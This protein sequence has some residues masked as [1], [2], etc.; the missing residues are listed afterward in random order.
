MQNLTQL[1]QYVLQDLQAQEKMCVEKYEKYTAQAKDEVL[2]NLF[3][4]IKDDEQKHLDSITQ[5]LGGTVPQV[6]M[7][8]NKAKDYAP[9]AT[10]TG[11]FSQEDKASD[12]FLCTDSITTEKYVSSAYNFDL[13]KFADSSVRELLADIEIEEQQHAEMIYKYKTVNQMV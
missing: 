1:Q 7:C 12:A 10:Y 3:T 2:K 11:S 8:D 6:N 9:T 4:K 13:F 5:I